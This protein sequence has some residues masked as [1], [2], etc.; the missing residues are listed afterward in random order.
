MFRTL[1]GRR[2]SFGVETNIYTKLLLHC[3]GLEGYSNF[4]DSSR[5]AHTVT[6]YG[7]ARMDTTDKKFGTS[8]GKLGANQDYLEISNSSDWNFGTDN[9]TVDLWAKYTY[10][11]TLRE[12]PIFT[13]G[14]EYWGFILQQGLFAMQYLCFQDNYLFTENWIASPGINAWTHMAVIRGWGGNSNNIAVTMNGTAV[15]VINATGWDFD[16]YEFN[17]G[18]ENDYLSNPTMS[19]SVDEVRV[20]KGIARWTS[21]FTPETEEYTI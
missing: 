7:I 12:G 19:G 21:N 13:V 3:D 17:V 4:V 8:S 5:S 14:D 15:K 16:C 1:M 2:S 11:S 9:F 10:L 6:P 20:S 18:F